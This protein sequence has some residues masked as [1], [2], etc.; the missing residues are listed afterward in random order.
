MQGSHCTCAALL[1]SLH[2]TTLP[3]A[4]GREPYPVEW[5]RQIGSIQ[6]D[7]GE[8]VAVDAAGNAYLTGRAGAL[9]EDY[10]GEYDAFLTK[11][12]STGAELW[13]RQ[14]G[15][16]KSDQSQSV[17][18]DSAGNVYITGGVGAALTPAGASE[19]GAFL[20]KWDSNGNEVWTRQIGAGGVNSSNAVVVDASDRVYI[21]GFTNDALQGPNAG[22]PDAFVARFDP[23]GDE[24]WLR[25]FGTSEHEV[26]H[27]IAVDTAGQ[28]YLAGETGGALGG[29]FLG[30][31]DAFLT[32]LDPS[33]DTLWTTQYGTND[34]DSAAAV[35]VDE[36]GNV[37]VTG[38]TKGML[39]DTR[40]G[41]AD[42][43]VAKFNSYGSPVWTTQ[44]GY[45]GDDAGQ[46]VAFDKAGNAH[47]T[48]YAA[49]DATAE[50]ADG[51]QVFLS[52]I[53]PAGD[54]VWDQQFGDRGEDYGAGIALDE[55][56]N[57]YVGGSTPSSYGG[58]ETGVF[59]AFLAKFRSPVPEPASTLL[60][61]T[62]AYGLA[63]GRWRS[64]HSP[65]R[66]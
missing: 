7:A 61:I 2:V 1:V 46:A 52:M 26:V 24:V 6:W 34:S 35:A 20:A 32:K 17:A 23:N 22:W 25:Q 45:K 16:S 54:L 49:G 33:G 41:G 59:N 13:T 64:Q 50:H 40:A 37:I 18:V 47:V 10:A 38:S 21:S 39:G 27:G 31:S 5:V 14:I 11:F 28:V 58:P 29:E 8:A 62:A 53:S 48:G 66:E 44:L 60:A 56:G 51:D 55:W 30:V 12:D 15:T 43:Y 4:C 57:V 3:I 42:A 65:R 9:N 19:G 36:N 63:N